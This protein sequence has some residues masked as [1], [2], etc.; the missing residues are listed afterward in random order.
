M[1]TNRETIERKCAV[2]GEVK[3]TDIR[4][5]YRWL[6]ANKGRPLEDYTCNSCTQKRAK[7]HGESGTN[8]HRRWKS[9]FARTKHSK[10]Y[11]EKGIKVCAE[12]YDYRAFRRWAL[13]NGFKPE[14]QLDRIDP[15]GDYS[16]NN[17]Q[18][19]SKLENVRKVWTDRDDA[20]IK[21]F[22]KSQNFG[23]HQRA[24]ADGKIPSETGGSDSFESGAA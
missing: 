3:T 20:T 4:N 13:K 16:P 11:S 17:C 14:L 24:D 9:L 12:W 21:R 15:D 5:F 19:I 2:C 8:L 23:Q 22:I 18:W 7:K 6:K 1:E 10:T